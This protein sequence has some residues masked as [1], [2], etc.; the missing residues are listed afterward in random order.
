MM[1]STIFRSSSATRMR[2]RLVKSPEAGGFIVDPEPGKHPGVAARGGETAGGNIST[3]P[4]KEHTAAGS[5]KVDVGKR[6]PAPPS[7]ASPP[8]RSAVPSSLPYSDLP[9]SQEPCMSADRVKAMIQRYVDSTHG[10]LSMMA[11]DV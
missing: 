3:R 9:F 1:Y 7:R 6:R 8:A 10:D 5:E 4:S 11:D 2:R